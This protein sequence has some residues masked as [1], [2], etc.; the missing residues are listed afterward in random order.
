MSLSF[1]AVILALGIALVLYYLTHARKGIDWLRTG[2]DRN[3]VKGKWTEIEKLISDGGTSNLRTAVI[4]ADKLFDYVL[5]WLVGSKSHWDKKKKM[6]GETMGER[7]KIAQK[8]FSRYD[9]Y[10]DVWEAHK[11]RNRVVHEVDNELLHHDA[12]KAIDYFRRGLRDLG[13]L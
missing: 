7:L 10:Q 1:L 12:K 2:L 3:K 4:E 9:I 6:R 11:L 5:K 8:R 13:V